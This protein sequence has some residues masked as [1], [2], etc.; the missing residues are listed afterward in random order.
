MPFPLST[1]RATLL[2]ATLLPAP[3]WA[4]VS[5][6]D[7][8][9]NLQ[10]YS[11]VF[12][13]TLSGEVTKSGDTLSMGD[14]RYSIDLPLNAGRF[15][16]GVGTLELQDNGN[17]TVDVVYPES[18]AYTFTFIDPK[19]EKTSA[20]IQIT[21]QSMSMTASGDPGDVLYAYSG[22]QVAFSVATDNL[23]PTLGS[24]E[25]DGHLKNFAGQM[26]VTTDDLVKIESIYQMGAFSY[27]TSQT[28]A[29]EL[30]RMVKVD[31][32]AGSD[33]MAGHGKAAFPRTGMSILN[34]SS[35]LRDGL[36]FEAS[37]ELFG[38]FTSQ[39]TSAEGKPVMAQKTNAASYRTDVAI[40][41]EG[42]RVSGPVKDMTVTVEF[43]DA[44][45]LPVTLSAASGTG[46]IT[47]PILKTDQVAPA[48]LS[49]DIEGIEIDPA[50]W[51]MFDPGSVLPRDPADLV[52]DLNGEVTNLV[53]WLDFMNLQAAIAK[54]KPNGPVLPHDVTLNTLRISAAGAEVTGK[55]K[56]SFDNGG[57]LPR[58]SGK[59][60]FD[61][62]GV[63]ALID[64][65]IKAGLV[66]DADASGARMGLAM[67]TKPAVGGGEDHVTSEVELTAEEH[68]L[69]NGVRIK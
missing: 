62:K 58:P 11:A 30:G 57:V 12:G 35:A 69:V 56:L 14:T 15:E 43:P 32:T 47:L 52:L 4:D 50:L 6:E 59:A 5:P 21:Q 44:F 60:N 64:G 41:A 10:D 27:V 2:C 18:Y 42:L 53:E 36:R 13:G 22:D 49:L 65:L 61:I 8:W 17:G 55:G 38:Y 20:E 1:H 34:L 28:Q 39:N 63:T 29:D 54:S 40:D 3:L 48:S 66:S 7:V 68:V 16:I 46:E 9:Q 19:G 45:P 33:K 26:R 51:D 31:I 67:M 23:P 25:I 37:T 24:P